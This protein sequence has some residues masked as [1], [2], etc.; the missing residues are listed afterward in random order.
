MKQIKRVLA[1][2]GAALLVLMY[3]ATLVCAIFGNGQEMAMFKAS[4][5]CTILVPVLLW[6]YTVIY[7]L[8]KG[9][10]EQELQET[11]ENLESKKTK[12]G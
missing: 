6:G 10:N 2:I 7:R 4:V 9:K 3:L 11:L 5:T 12:N 1:L 8:A